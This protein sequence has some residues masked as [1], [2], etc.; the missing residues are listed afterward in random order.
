M[1]HFCEIIHTLSFAKSSVAQ[2]CQLLSISLQFYP[3]FI[4][5]NIV[6]LY[7]CIHRENSR[8]EGHKSDVDLAET[9]YILSQGRAGQF[10]KKVIRERVGQINAGD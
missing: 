10:V 9:N 8:L 2:G 1:S 7:S 4:C 3:S 5:Q 6:V